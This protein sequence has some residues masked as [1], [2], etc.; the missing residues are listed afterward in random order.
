MFQENKIL[1][2]VVITFGGA[3]SRDA[4]VQYYI[5]GFGYEIRLMDVL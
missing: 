4:F 5:E 2:D 3:L 1:W